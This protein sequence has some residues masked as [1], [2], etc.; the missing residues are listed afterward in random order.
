VCWNTKVV[1]VSVLCSSA[2]AIHCSVS[3]VQGDYKWIHSFVYGSNNG[4]KCRELWKEMGSVHDL[5]DKSPWLR[6][7]SMW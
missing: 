3:L 2:Q 5:I 4:V 1:N 7:I 6:V